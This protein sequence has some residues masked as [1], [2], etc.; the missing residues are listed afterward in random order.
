MIVAREA[1][2]NVFRGRAAG[3]SGRAPRRDGVP[4]WN[5]HVLHRAGSLDTAVA[6]AR[7]RNLLV[8]FGVL[9]LL[10]A[11]MGLV[12][13]TSSARAHAWPRSRWSSSPACRTSCGRRSP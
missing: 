9:L 1:R 4:R 8:S 13:V 7:R 12:L 6:H 2:G 10:G 3:R 11:S 5:V